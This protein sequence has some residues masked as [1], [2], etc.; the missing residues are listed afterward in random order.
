VSVGF[1]LENESQLK[2]VVVAL[3]T[4][5][6]ATLQP[7][8]AQTPALA[9]SSP[10]ATE[11]ARRIAAT[12]TLAAQEYRLAWQNGRLTAPAEWEEAKLFVAEAHHTARSLPPALAHEFDNRLTVLE[13]RL[14]AQF[15]AESLAL[16]ARAIE[17]RLSTALG[18]TL[19]DRPAREPSINNGE[20]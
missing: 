6:A 16:E 20:V 3:T 9:Q 5:F 7:A 13:S 11:S 2:L 18:V 12:L 10:D 15:P 17:V 8:S 4:L 14:A 1:T 19:D